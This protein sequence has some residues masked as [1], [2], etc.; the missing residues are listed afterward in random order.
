MAK[1]KVVLKRDN[2]R[3]MKKSEQCL[4]EKMNALAFS[5]SH[6]HQSSLSMITSVLCLI[7]PIG[8]TFS[9]RFSCSLKALENEIGF[10]QGIRYNDVN[11]EQL[12]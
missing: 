2:Y 6:I 8:S 12:N 10:L 7:P 1:Q 11:P 5:N 3:C 9:S 4:S